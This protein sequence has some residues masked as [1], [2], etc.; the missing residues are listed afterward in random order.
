M[1]YYKVLTI[2]ASWINFCL[3]NGFQDAPVRSCGRVQ[4]AA[5][6]TS[7]ASRLLRPGHGVRSFVR[8]R[9]RSFTGQDVSMCLRFLGFTYF[10]LNF[11]MHCTPFSKWSTNDVTLEKKVDPQ[12]M[13]RILSVKCCFILFIRCPQFEV[14]SYVI[15]VFL[16]SLSQQ[17]CTHIC[18][19]SYLHQMSFVLLF[20]IVWASK[21]CI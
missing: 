4:A 21:K 11:K 17:I 12:K 19:F 15:C 20:E 10:D 3:F 7:R 5:T 6:T 14:Q 9:I 1:S 13:L 8:W 16:T 18:V 2:I